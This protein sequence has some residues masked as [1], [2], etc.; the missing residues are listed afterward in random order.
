[1]QT[2]VNISDTYKFGFHD[3]IKSVLS[4]KKGLSRHVVEEISRMKDEPEWMRDSRLRAYDIFLAKTLPMWGGDLTRLNFDNI[5]YY[6]KPFDKQG[7]TWDDVPAEIKNTFDKLGIPQAERKFLAGVGAQYDSE[8]VYHSISKMLEKK[9]VIFVDT[10]TAVKKYP[11]LLREY[12]GKIIPPADNKFAALNTAVWSGGSF[13]YVPKGVRVELPLQAYFRINAKNMGQFERTLIIADEGSYVH[14]VEGCFLAGARVRTDQGE[15]L[16]ETIT[17]GDNVLTHKGRYKRVYKTMKRSYKGKIFTIKYYGDGEAKLRVTKE[18][19]LLV[20]KRQK[21]EYRNKHFVPQWLHADQVRRGDYL[22]YP[23]LQKETEKEITETETVKMTPINFKRPFIYNYQPTVNLDIPFGY[24][25]H[26]SQKSLSLKL[27][28]DFYRL[29]GYFFAEGH[30]D[31]EHYLTFTF[32]M[33]EK[34]FIEDVKRLLHRY[35]GKEV[36]EGKIRNNGQTLT[37]CS[38]IAARFFA[39]TFGSTNESKHISRWILESPKE[40]LEQLIKGMWGGDG[41]YYKKS[42]LFRYSSVTRSLAFGFRDAL[43]KLGV[44]ASINAQ[45]RKSPKQIMYSVIVSRTCNV[46][47]GKFV[48]KETV[49]GRKEGSPFYIDERYMYV[50][51]KS[52]HTEDR[53]DLVYNFSVTEDESYVAEGVVS[54]N[55][56]APIFTTD[57]LHSAVVEIIVKK[58][59]RVRYTTIQNWSKNVYNLVT[60]R[61]F[62]EEEGIGEWVDGNLGSQLTM[63]YPSVYLKGRKARGEILSLAFAGEGQHQDAGGK[64]IHLAPETSSVITSKSISK[65]GGRTSYRGML[66]VAKGAVGSKSTVRCDALILDDKSRSDTYPT[67]QIDEKDVNI[68]HEARVSKI[69]EEQLFYFQSR[70]IDQAAAETMIVNGFIEPIVKE[71][72]MEYAVEMNRLIQLN[73]EGAVG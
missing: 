63:K 60:K 33:S 16:I 18:H 11:E 59:A 15:K 32:H 5:Y 13:I 49:D 4:T 46:L 23:L 61:M 41:S 21:R 17:A 71:L 68:G 58:G 6:I 70:G 42:Q 2:S 51:I 14:Y 34:V 8:V 29:I 36:I 64:A 39:R 52:I 62:V 37:L 26:I 69:G 48:G 56:T 38:T 57:S 12:F 31:N 20:C 25:R 24:G 45:K 19:P 22:V 73:M 10:D 50:P 55:C 35:F 9:G 66:K 54:H 27:D 1:M 3:K 65:K 67:M 28:P 47:F 53:E 40:H 72:P 43:L 7:K 44:I 30:I